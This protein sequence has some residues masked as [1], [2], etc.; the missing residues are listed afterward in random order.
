MKSG[1]R[2]NWFLSRAMLR[3]YDQTYCTSTVMQQLKAVFDQ[4]L[5][6]AGRS[7]SAP[8][9]FSVANLHS[10]AIEFTPLGKR[11]RIQWP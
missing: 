2:E 8:A 4:A 6:L 1:E 11:L 3:L 9:I 5:G 7:I 10:P